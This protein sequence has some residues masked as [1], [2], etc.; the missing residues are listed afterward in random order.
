[1]ANL[2]PNE[3]PL[4]TLS[5]TR[6][7]SSTS[8]AHGSGA[9]KKKKLD[10]SPLAK[11]FDLQTRAQLYAEIAK[12]FYTSGLSFNSVRN[13][14]YLSSSTFAAN[15]RISGYVPPSYNK[16]RTTLLQQGKANVEMLLAPMKSTWMAKG[17]S[18]VSDGWSDPQ[19][20]PLINFMVV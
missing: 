18:I 8:V 3:I 13:P 7:S 19:S 1:R 10:D 17:V 2:K 11:A 5:S 4:P 14:Y 16:L 6:T 15:S 9:I 12:M 20:R